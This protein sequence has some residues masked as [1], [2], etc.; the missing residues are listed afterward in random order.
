M[1]WQQPLALLIVVSTGVAFVWNKARASRYSFERD[2]HCGCG[3]AGGGGEIGPRQTI[4]FRA[5]KGERP[6]VVIKNP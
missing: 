2:S 3:S 6:K 4:Q 5:R 1:D